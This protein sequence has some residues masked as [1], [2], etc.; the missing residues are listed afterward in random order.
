MEGT[1]AGAGDNFQDWEVLHNSDSDSDSDSGL[2]NLDRPDEKLRN[3]EEI[4]GDYSEG[5]IRSDYFSLD[6]ENIYAKTS[7]VNVS[8]E[9]S[10]ESDNPSWIDPGSETRY[11]RKNSGEFWSDS[12]SDQSDERKFGDFQV[13]CEGVGEALVVPKSVGLIK[14]SGFDGIPEHGSSCL[15]VEKEGE[16]SVDVHVKKHDESQIIIGES[17]D[18]GSVSVEANLSVASEETRA[19]SKACI[20]WWKVPF[21]V[22]K[23][24]VLKVNPVWSFSVAAAVMGL[25]IL[26]RK[27]YKMKRKTRSL[28]LKVTLDDKKVSQFMSRAARLNEAFSVVRRVPIIRP[29]LPAP[30]V[31]S[32]PVMSLR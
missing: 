19:L 28:E 27:L 20:V 11:Q 14:I 18:D 3:F 10:V 31:N 17:G 8:E 13:G 30:G 9:G 5:I 24:C 22:L 25:V 21:E 7:V 29:A 16:T 26:G 1:G 23:Y 32:W 15:G 6:N 12:G 2:F 4:E